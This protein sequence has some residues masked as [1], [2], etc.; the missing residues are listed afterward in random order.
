MEVRIPFEDYLHVRVVRVHHIRTGAD[1][2]PVEGDV[3]VREQSLV[4]KLGRL[5][6]H[7]R[8][9]GHGEPVGELGVFRLEYYP[10][11][12]VV[13]LLDAR[14]RVFPVVERDRVCFFVD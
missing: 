1:R 8:E 12:M 4:V 14:Q 9:K 11:G 13:D 5:P 3:D 2:E 7:G 10:E 6:W